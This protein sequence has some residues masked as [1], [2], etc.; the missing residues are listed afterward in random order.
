LALGML[1]LCC[2]VLR[3]LSIIGEF[4]FACEATP[5]AAAV[6]ESTHHEAGPRC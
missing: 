5:A 6:A 4:V 1:W 3:L 2:A